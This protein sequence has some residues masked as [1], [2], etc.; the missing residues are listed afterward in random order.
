[1][2]SI[3]NIEQLSKQE[4]K[5]ELKKLGAK[6]DKKD[7]S[8][9]YY[10]NI[11]S[12]LMNSKN[13][14][15]SDNVQPDNT[16]FNKGKRGRDNDNTPVYEEIQGG[17]DQ[18]LIEDLSDEGASKDWKNRY[19]A[20]RRVNLQESGIKVTRLKRLK[21][22]VNENNNI[23]TNNAQGMGYIYQEN[24]NN[25]PGIENLNYTQQN[26][27]PNLINLN[28][29]E[30]YTVSRNIYGSNGQ[31]TQDQLR[32]NEVGF[33]FNE[34]NGPNTK[35]ESNDFIGEFRADPNK[36]K[37]S[38]KYDFY[39]KSDSEDLPLLENKIKETVENDRRKFSNV[40]RG[41]GEFRKMTQDN[42]NA[43][44]VGLDINQ[45]GQEGK[46]IDNPNQN[47][48]I[49]L[50]EEDDQHSSYSRFS[51]GTIRSIFNKEIIPKRLKK[52]MFLLPLI[53]FIL[54]VLIFFIHGKNENIY[55]KNILIGFTIIMG[56][57]ILYHGF[58]YLKE[59]IDY[60]KMAKIDHEQLRNILL[61]EQVTPENLSGQL[62][63]LNKFISER[64]AFH[65]IDNDTYLR[66]V[67]PHLAKYL[68]NDGYILQKGENNEEEGEKKDEE[69]PKNENKYWKE[70]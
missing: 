27:R 30:N 14:F 63:L 25:I 28:E 26:Q 59:L 7:H 24:I 17:N 55:L 20:D 50:D 35:K 33:S 1:M 39:L 61:S 21:K 37:G 15:P 64:V 62:I 6:L 19:S 8:K 41:E 44:G 52:H 68:K 51:F 3:Q 46:K 9:S 18:D 12:E 13:N 47:T 53:F 32:R 60:R 40:Q 11:Y 49:H 29:E 5:E 34:K 16:Q 54:L 65:N 66:C 10:L 4:I 43:G 22:P 70:L 23:N 57:L 38:K 69:E 48:N 36:R 31:G 45:D 42:N 58:K 56:L 67:F 2:S